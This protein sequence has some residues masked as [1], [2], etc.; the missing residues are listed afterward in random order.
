MKK[1][2]V[3]ALC[4]LENKFFFEKIVVRVGGDDECG[5]RPK[6]TDAGGKPRYW[7]D[8]VVNPGRWSLFGGENA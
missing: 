6:K 2:R 3:Q 1:G 8:G 7:R 5:L 4:E